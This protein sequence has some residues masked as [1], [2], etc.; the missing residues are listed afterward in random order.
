MGLHTWQHKMSGVCETGGLFKQLFLDHE[1]KRIVWKAKNPALYKV[2]T[3]LSV[4]IWQKKMISS[5]LHM[6]FLLD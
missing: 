3:I 1:P 5:L 2:G 6:R 4:H